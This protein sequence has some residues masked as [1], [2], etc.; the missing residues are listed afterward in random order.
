MVSISLRGKPKFKEGAKSNG[1]KYTNRN[2]TKREGK[3]TKTKLAEI[4]G[5]LVQLVREEDMSKS[6][7]WGRCRVRDVVGNPQAL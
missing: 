4:I 7:S 2:L 6:F 1:H 3:K 5:V